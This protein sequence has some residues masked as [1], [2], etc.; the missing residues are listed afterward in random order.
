MAVASVPRAA[1]GDAMAIEQSRHEREAAQQRA[2]RE[3]LQS[4]GHETETVGSSSLVRAAK[5]AAD[6]FAARDTEV[7]AGGMPDPVELWGRRI[8]RAL[9]LAAFVGL[10]IYLYAT[11]LR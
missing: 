7:A 10:A 11:Y 5:R 2:A 4:L 6:H 3:R 9:S 1:Y 8:G